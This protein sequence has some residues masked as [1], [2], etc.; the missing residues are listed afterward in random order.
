MITK[1]IHTFPI[2]FCIMFGMD[3]HGSLNI[4]SMKLFHTL[5]AWR[6]FNAY[7]KIYLEISLH[8]AFVYN[9]FVV[10]ILLIIDDTNLFFC[11]CVCV[12]VCTSNQILSFLIAKP[13]HERPCEPNHAL[14][15]WS[16][17]SPWVQQLEG[18]CFLHVSHK[19]WQMNIYMYNACIYNVRNQD[20]GEGK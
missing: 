2:V 4:P 14:D 7:C 5:D 15:S 12:C 16:Y 8:C 9:V 6:T 11:V 13:Q 10:R 19:Q 18:T 17:L 20:E 3:A 1:Q